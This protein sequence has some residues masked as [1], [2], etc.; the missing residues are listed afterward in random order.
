MK[1]FKLRKI[2]A[3]IVLFTGMVIGFQ[4][5]CLAAVNIV[6]EIAPKDTLTAGVWA[7]TDVR[8]GGSAGIA[9]LTG[10]GGNLENNQPSPIDAALLTTDFTDAAKAEV[11]VYNDYGLAGDIIASL[12]LAFDFY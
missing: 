5:V 7:A 2:T 12:Q 6:T 9:D 1:H 3:S 11:G 4:G 10:L 8:P